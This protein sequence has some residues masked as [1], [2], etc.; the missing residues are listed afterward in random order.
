MGGH[1]L[2]NEQ[3]W[4]AK[5][6]TNIKCDIL[7]IVKTRNQEGFIT[8]KKQV[9]VYIDLDKIQKI[10]RDLLQSFKLKRKESNGNL[11]YNKMRLDAVIGKNKLI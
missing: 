5:W 11:E 8:S 4:T 3:N 2:V 10:I 1:I 6:S 9:N 7:R